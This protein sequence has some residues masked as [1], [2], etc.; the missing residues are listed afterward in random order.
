MSHHLSEK[1]LD[2]IFNPQTIAVIGASDKQGGVGNALMKN[3]IGNNYQG[4]VYPVNPNRESVQGIKAYVKVSD[5][6]DKIDLA[7]ICTPAVTVPAIVEECGQAGVSGLVIISSGFDEIGE[8]G[9]KMSEEILSIANTYNMRVVGPNCL[10][11]I[12]PSINLNASFANKMALP[13]HIAFISQSGAL[14]TSIL[15]WSVKNNVGFSHFVSIGSNIDISFHDLIDYFGDDP[16][17][18]SILI[19]MESLKEARKFMSAARAFSRKKPIVVLKVG[20]T[21]AGSRAAKSHTGAITGNDSVYDAAFERAGIIRVDGALELFHVAKSL[22]MQKRPLDNRVAVITNAGGPGVIAADRLAL[23]G[24]RLA[25][26]SH[27]TVEALKNILPASASTV[28]PVDILGDADSLR[29]RQAV[30]LCLEDSGVDAALIILTPQEMTSPTDVARQIV[31]VQ[32]KKGKMIF[33][34]WMGGDDVAEG[35]VILEQ[36]NIPIYRTPEEA[37]DIFMYVDS[38][39]KRLEFLKETPGSIPHAFKP[40]TEAN[41]KLIEKVVASGRT[42]LTE[43]EAKEMIANYGIPVAKNGVANSATEAG[44]IAEKTGFPVVMKILSPDI[45]HKTDIGGVKLN[46]NSKAEAE[47]A[48]KEII[49]GAKKGAPKAKIDGVFIEVM[50]K[51][52]YELLIGCKKDEVFGPAIVFGMGGVAV[53]VFRDTAVGLPPLNMSLALKMIQETKIYK[54]LKGYRGMPGVDIPAIQFLLYKFAYLVSD[55]PEIKELDINPFAVD[56]KGGVVLDAKVILDEKVLGVKHKPYSHLVISP[57]PREYEKKIVLEN[58]KNILIRPIRPEDEDLEM[59]MINNFSATTMRDRF[60]GKVKKVNL[61]ML[62][63]FT[64][65]DYDREIALVAETE[66]RKKKKFVGVV[67]LAIDPYNESALLTIALVDSWQEM[68]LGS[69]MI[70]YMLDIARAR[71]VKKVWME[72]FPTN[73]RIIKILTK[74]N[75]TMKEKGS[76]MV[77]E[78]E[79]ED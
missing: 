11:F 4:I 40:K 38:Y 36:G 5:I 23:K 56:E 51:K 26:L 10:G 47:K 45:L 12:R 1:R 9:K 15:D 8:K 35:R 28:N 78:L 32:N 72:F 53:E 50:T 6:P 58:K 37:V 31:S 57:Y 79:L 73:K 61:E 7:I 67:R 17:T 68:T 20:R 16:E 44:E 34:S 39:R 76:I 42:V 59:E 64:Q 74:R 62:R 55:F 63:G 48:Y 54:L 14:C 41:K 69:E 2:K 71:G 13:G 29:Y 33:A 52:R 75:F 49:A 27:K 65:I 18:D 70:D 19:Y 25:E 43:I 46:I 24:G 3:L 60:L 22:A 66:E 30:E 21:E 77:G